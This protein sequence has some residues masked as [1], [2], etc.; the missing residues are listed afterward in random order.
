MK[1]NI[2]MPGLTSTP[3]MTELNMSYNTN[4]ADA[5]VPDAYTRLI[6]DVLRGQQAAFV[7]TDELKAAW[8]IFTPL[9]HEIDENKTKPI[10]YVFGSRGPKEADDMISQFYSRPKSYKWEGKEFGSILETEHI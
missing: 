7:R 2:K 8:E 9:L 4:F 6:L 5:N 10:D 3:V 1:C